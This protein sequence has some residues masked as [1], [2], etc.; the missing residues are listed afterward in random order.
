MSEQ[1]MTIGFLAV[2]NAQQPGI[3]ILP[4]D[5]VPHGDSCNCGA[6][7]DDFSVYLLGG[8]DLD[9]ALALFTLLAD[10]I[11]KSTVRDPYT[12]KLVLG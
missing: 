11:T 12:G 2:P 8:V 9:D 4:N 10:E 5:P 3:S 1:E 7:K 6:G